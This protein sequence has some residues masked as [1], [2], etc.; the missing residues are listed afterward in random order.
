MPWETLPDDPQANLAIFHQ[1]HTSCIARPIHES[2]S[3]ARLMPPGLKQFEIMVEGILGE[4][5]G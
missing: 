3:E 4:V 5:C 1:S 2:A